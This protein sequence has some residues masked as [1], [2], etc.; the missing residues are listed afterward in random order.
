[1]TRT[2]E[3][4]LGRR[5]GG[6]TLAVGDKRI[7]AG[8]LSLAQ[9]AGLSVI[10]SAPSPKLENAKVLASRIVESPLTISSIL[11]KRGEAYYLEQLLRDVDAVVDVSGF[12]YADEWGAGGAERL[13]RLLKRTRAEG[14]PYLMCPQTYGPFSGSRLRE[15]CQSALPQVDLLVARDAESRHHLADLLGRPVE[16][17]ALSPDIAFLFQPAPDVQA[18]SFVREHGLDP[19][20]PFAVVVPNMRVYERA[21]GI[22]S[23]NTYLETMAEAVRTLRAK[24]AQVLLM[25]HEVRPQQERKPDDRVLCDT[26]ALMAHTEAGPP[27]GAVLGD[28]P[29]ALLKAAIGKAELVVGSRFHALVAA[30]SMAVPPVAVGWAHKYEELLDDFGLRR[31]VLDRSALGET[32]FADTVREA[33]TLR[34]DSQAA[35]RERLPAV[36]ATVS[37]LF[38]GA[39]ATISAAA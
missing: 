36:K 14:I 7:A 5:L 21:E 20:A 35:I 13:V 12:L 23:R 31:F 17:V 24:G 4:E 22:G 19:E 6:V 26:L 1:M 27:V 37:S 34:A 2:V 18:M 33:W 29:S 39:A 28:V 30:L 15:L 9:S 8:N 10:R 11:A 38:D 25:P 32:A 3:A 16:E